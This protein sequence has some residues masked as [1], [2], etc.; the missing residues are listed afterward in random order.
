[1]QLAVTLLGLNVHRFISEICLTIS[2]CKCILLDA[3][4]SRLGKASAAYLLIEGNWNH[5]AR[6]ENN[7]AVLQEKLGIQ[8]HT[9]RVDKLEKNI[10][11]MPYSLEVITLE[12]DETLQSILTFLNE[13]NIAIQEFN[14]SRYPTHYNQSLIFSVKMVIIIPKEAPLLSIREQFLDFCDQLNLDAILEPIKR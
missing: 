9:L 3:S 6:F 1:M 4:S 12:Q 7:L 10:D 8:A 5:I 14:A 2:D 13:N 11:G